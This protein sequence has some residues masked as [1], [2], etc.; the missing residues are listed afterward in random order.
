[1]NLER[2]SE[3]LQKAQNI[4]LEDGW[5]QY[6]HKTGDGRHCMLGALY[7]AAGFYHSEP[8]AYRLEWDDSRFKLVVY[9]AFQ[10]LHTAVGIPEASIS[11]TV[12][13]VNDNFSTTFTD[14][15]NW[16]DKAILLAKEA[17]SL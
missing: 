8:E 6:Y 7:E 12:S 15:M 13:M 14:V 10:Y 17:E 1:M 16:F 5:A 11:E 3:I 2:P 9:P 4:L